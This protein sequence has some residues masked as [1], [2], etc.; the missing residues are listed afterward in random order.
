MTRRLFM[1]STLYAKQ[2]RLQMPWVHI[3]VLCVAIVLGGC[4][5]AAYLLWSNPARAITASS[6]C[7]NE[8]PYPPLYAVCTGY[9]NYCNFGLLCSP[10]P[11]TP[12]TNNPSGYTPRCDG[13]YKCP[14]ES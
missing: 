1:T 11:G 4:L 14:W 5:A 9:G 7:T 13:N 12:G 6:Y 2:P 8:M 3:R 10:V